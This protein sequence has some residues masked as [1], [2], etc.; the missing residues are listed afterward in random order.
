VL[1]NEQAE[2]RVKVNARHEAI[3]GSGGVAPLNLNISTIRRSVSTPEKGGPRYTLT[4]SLGEPQ[5]QSGGF[6]EWEHLMSLLGI[7]TMIA[8]LANP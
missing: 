2:I 7:V 6:K 3:W 8:W 1:P 4:W 5:S